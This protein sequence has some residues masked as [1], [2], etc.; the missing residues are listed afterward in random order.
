MEH[1]YAMTLQKSQSAPKYL[2]QHSTAYRVSSR[3]IF[4][5]SE[6][7]ELWNT[8]EQ[9]LLSCLQTGD[10]KSARMCLERLSGRFGPSNERVMGLRG[11]YEEAIAANAQ[12][13]ERILKE[14]ESTLSKNPVNMV[15][16]L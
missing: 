4:G 1:S 9:L 8:Y 11:M 16:L 15:S 10:D 3:N 14:Y 5:G 7:T 12:V 13:L 6:S 2:E